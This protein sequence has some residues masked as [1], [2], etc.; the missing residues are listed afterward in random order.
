MSYLN[1][2]S[3]IDLFYVFLIIDFSVS[4]KITIYF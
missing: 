2:R 1:S 4:K 3:E